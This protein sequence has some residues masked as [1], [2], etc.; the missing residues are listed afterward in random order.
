MEG[1][2]SYFGF[3]SIDLMGISK[4]ELTVVADL[5]RDMAG[6]EVECRLDGLTGALI[7]KSGDLQASVEGEPIKVDFELKGKNL[8]GKHDIIFLFILP[9]L[10]WDDSS[11]FY[12]RKFFSPCSIIA[13]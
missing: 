5:W 12:S 4:I 9:I 11:F 2:G 1:D 6:G 13:I 8:T 10:A 3:R 7:G